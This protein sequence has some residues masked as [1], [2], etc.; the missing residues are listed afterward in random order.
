MSNNTINIGSAQ[1]TQIQQ[2]VSNS[3]QNLHVN[4]FDKDL[5]GFVESFIPDIS[6]I[7][8]ERTAQLLKADA[9]TIK[10]QIDSPAPK[11]GIMKEC[12]LSIKNVL[13]GAAGNVLASYIPVIIPLLMC[14]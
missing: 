2:D 4:N 6:K 7:K 11:K 5:K 14:L 13:E 10:F 8:D 1:N 12:L 9:E 3:S